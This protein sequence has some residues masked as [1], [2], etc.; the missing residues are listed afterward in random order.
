MKWLPRRARRCSAVGWVHVVSESWNGHRFFVI[1]KYIVNNEFFI[2][3][4]GCGV[5]ACVLTPS[6]PMMVSWLSATVRL[7]LRSCDRMRYAGLLLCSAVLHRG[8]RSVHPIFAFQRYSLR[9]FYNSVNPFSASVIAHYDWVLPFGV[10]F[11][12]TLLYFESVVRVVWRLR[13]TDGCVRKPTGVVCGVGS[14]GWL[15]DGFCCNHESIVGNGFFGNY[16]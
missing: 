2:D 1:S 12:A 8:N 16:T 14:E 5:F 3:A 9:H 15:V 13:I 10:C 11:L 6:E 4:C 7:Y